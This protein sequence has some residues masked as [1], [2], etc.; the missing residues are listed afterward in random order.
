MVISI[1]MISYANI[2]GLGFTYDSFDYYAAAQ[3][4]KSKNILI[5]H[6]GSL[7]NFHAPL[8]PILISI[9][10]SGN[11][12]LLMVMNGVVGLTT[13][14]LLS[15]SIRKLFENEFLF[16][17][18]YMSIVLNV[19]FFMIHHFLWTE[20][21]FLLL[22][23][24]HNY[25]LCRFLTTFKTRDFLGLIFIAFA[26]G[27]LKNTGFFIILVT[28]FIILFSQKKTAF[29]Y[30]INYLIV[31]S[32]GFIIWNLSVLYFRDGQ[33]VYLGS[34]FL[35]GFKENLPNYMDVISQWF[36]PSVFPLFIRLILIAIAAVLLCVLICKKI[37]RLQ[38]RIFFTQFFGYLVIMVFIIEVDFDE[39]E[40]LLAIVAPWLLIAIFMTIDINWSNLPMIARKYLSLLLI[41]WI[42]YVGIRSVNNVILWHQ[43]M[44]NEEFLSNFSF[45]L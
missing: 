25:L 40:R 32:F 36:F 8:F 23:L 29:K 20:P 5:N 19:G 4:W 41:I 17:L 22:F 42:A 9:F 10:T 35:Q 14:I 44:C 28:A 1:S 3:S 33:S 13:L 24:L 11:T 12:V 39:I 16:I 43:G 38:A 34:N 45:A 30:P 31:G 7:Y 15:I 18:T 27:V 21:I 37:P 2:C 26:L 6:N